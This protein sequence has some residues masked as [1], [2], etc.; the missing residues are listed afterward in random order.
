MPLVAFLFGYERPDFIRLHIRSQH[1]TDLGIHERLGAF[2]GN[3]HQPHDGLF[4]QA[5]YPRRTP[6]RVA[7][8]NQGNG[9]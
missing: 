4:V 1:V 8:D 6:D 7:F 2:P 5:G 3:H 9:E